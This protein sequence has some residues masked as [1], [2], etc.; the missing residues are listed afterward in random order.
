MKKTFT[1][2]LGLA[3]FAFLLLPAGASAVTVTPPQF[4]DFLLNPGDSAV[5]VIGVTN[6]GSTTEVFYPV[7]MNFSADQL[8]GGTP[9]FYSPDEDRMGQGLA[10]WITVSAEP[11]VLE[12]GERTDVTFVINVPEENVQPGGHYGAIMISS[13][14]PDEEGGMVGVASQLATL[15]M[16]RVSG[17]VREVGS[18]SEFSFKEPKVWYNHLPIDFILRFEN[19][20]N[21]HLRP[22]GNLIVTNWL[23][24]KTTSIKVNEDFKSVLPM[25][26]RKYEF[27]W[28]KGPLNDE[29]SGLNREWHNFGLGKY[30]AQ[31]ILNYGSTN[32]IIVDEREFY[33]WPWRLMILAGIGL[34]TILVLLTIMKHSYDKS[35]MR[36]YEKMQLK[37]EKRK[38]GEVKK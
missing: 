11:I 2:I 9:Q 36:K 37:A 35:L 12:P 29:M 27:G 3:M 15:I 4:P 14:P 22:T 10:Q 32:Q 17:D 13:S 26:V 31:L 16:V 5:G 20:G 38:S 34:L 28:H 7:K 23:G 30:K 8:E 1:T 25:S 6:E 33:V 21:T 19:A 18:I 24:N